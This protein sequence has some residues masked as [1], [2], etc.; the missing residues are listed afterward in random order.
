MILVFS[1]TNEAHAAARSLVITI[2]VSPQAKYGYNQLVTD[3]RSLIRSILRSKTVPSEQVPELPRAYLTVKQGDKQTEYLID[4]SWR[5]FRLNEQIILDLTPET[6]EKLKLCV[7][8]A[9]AKYYGEVVPWDKV[10]E[11]FPKKTNV[12]VIDLETGLAFQVQR[13]AGSQHADVQPLTREDSRIMRSIY[14]GKWSWKRRA[15]LVK[16]GDRSIAASMNGMPHG[17]GAIKGNDFPG[18][19]CIHFEGSTTHRLRKRDAGHYLMI[20]KASGRLNHEIVHS[21]P[22]QLVDLFLAAVKAQ[23]LHAAKLMLDHSNPQ[24]VGEFL[25]RAREIEDIRVIKNKEGQNETEQSW[26]TSQFA[27]IPVRVSVTLASSG[28]ERR[29]NL[30]FVVKRSSLSDRWKIDVDSVSSLLDPINEGQPKPDKQAMAASMTIS[31]FS[32]PSQAV[33]RFSSR[34]AQIW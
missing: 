21:T 25:D 7:Q 6:K 27:E 31:A 14:N 15:I 23:D 16:V 34:L 12:Q 30:T 5:V 1:Q 24:A 8:R 28:K 29:Q 3:D 26:D 11:L 10:E 33:Y 19:F 17:A 18:H 4:D 9:E 20:R 22:E 13:R 32:V 2:K